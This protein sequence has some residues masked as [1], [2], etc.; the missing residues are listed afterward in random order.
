MEVNEL[1]NNCP[2]IIFFI[3][4][5][6]FMSWVLPIGMQ[7]FGKFLLIKDKVLIVKFASFFKFP[8]PKT[9]IIDTGIL[10]SFINK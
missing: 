7:P 9:D 6:R 8:P 10:F 2:S 3:L 4:I 1:S 5:S